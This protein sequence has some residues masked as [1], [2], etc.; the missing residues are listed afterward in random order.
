MRVS[1]VRVMNNEVCSIV[2]GYQSWMMMACVYCC[3]HC[4]YIYWCLLDFW[5]VVF[6]GM[7]GVEEVEEER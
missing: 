7:C 5:C 1:I 6:S 3:Y 4:M 2:I